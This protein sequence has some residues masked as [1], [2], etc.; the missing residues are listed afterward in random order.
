MKRPSLAMP[1]LSNWSPIISDPN[2]CWLT[3]FWSCGFELQILKL[4]RSNRHNL[5]GHSEQ[6]WSPLMFSMDIHLHLIQHTHVL[7]TPGG[8]AVWVRISSPTP[9]GKHIKA[10]IVH[11]VFIVCMECVCA[12]ARVCLYVCKDKMASTAFSTRQIR[13]RGTL[14]VGIRSRDPIDL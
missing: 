6:W 1:F 2:V 12:R 11:T 14:I 7:L 4:S 10:C 13:I 5:R 8:F 9:A 3:A